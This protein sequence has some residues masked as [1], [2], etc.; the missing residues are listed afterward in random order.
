VGVASVTPKAAGSGSVQGDLWGARARDWADFQEGT[1]LSL[2]EAVLE[3]AALR[4]GTRLFDAGCGAGM[5]CLLAAARGAEVKGLDAAA[6]L[7]DIARGRLPNAEFRLGDLEQLPYVDESFDVVTG[8]NSFQYAADPI[9]A[10]QEVRR[11]A[12]R[13]AAVFI[14]TWAR[15]QDCEAAAYLAALASLAPPPP[16]GTP[17]PFALSEPGALER[18]AREGGL[19]ARESAEV[20]CI[21]RYPDLDTALRGLLSAG[22]AVRAI[23]HSGVSRVR[24]AAAAAISPFRTVRGGYQLENRFR[25]LVAQA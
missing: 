19:T 7:L 14:A 24:A 23:R 6:A 8:F 22:P 20:D 9:V 17:G 21:W 10:L 25:Y 12:K 13:G 3:R 15:P 11:V 2:Y 18:L 4:K 16:P 1:V 5:F